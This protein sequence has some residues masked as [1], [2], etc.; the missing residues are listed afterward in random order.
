MRY[1]PLIVGS[2]VAA[3]FLVAFWQLAE[4]FVGSPRVIAF[5][6]SVSAAIQ[7][8]RTPP[9][10]AVMVGITNAGDTPAI[11]LAAFALFIAFAA[12]GKWLEAS[13]TGG[14]VLVGG[15][16]SSLAKG[17]FARAR[18]PFEQALIDLPRSFSFPSGHTMGSMIFAFVMGYLVVRSGWQLW[19]RLAVLGVWAAYTILVGISRVY[20]GVHWPSDVLAAWLLGGALSAF[21]VGVYETWFAAAGADQG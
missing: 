17:S 8:W 16:L 19:A 12:L 14:V 9:L 11:A 5:D 3:V 18:P 20:L 10:T 21:S 4:G 6:A 2:T 7:S 13:F 1:R 15:L